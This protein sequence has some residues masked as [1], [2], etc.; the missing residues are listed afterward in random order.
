MA[1]AQNASYASSAATGIATGQR[2]EK[3]SSLNCLR[4]SINSFSAK[5]KAA[6]YIITLLENEQ[7]VAT[8]VEKLAMCLVVL[9]LHIRNLSL[10]IG[11]ALP[12][13]NLKY[14]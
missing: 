3:R 6:I 1:L 10:G 12:D 14:T 4:A 5:P 13:S 7:K 8:F 11:V 9:L 2:Q